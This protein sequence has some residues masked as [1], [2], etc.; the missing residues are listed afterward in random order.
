MLHDISSSTIVVQVII[1]SPYLNIV[2]REVK[3]GEIKSAYFVSVR[4]WDFSNKNK[5]IQVRVLQFVQICLPWDYYEYK[6]YK[7]VYWKNDEAVDIFIYLHE[8]EYTVTLPSQCRG[9]WNGTVRTTVCTKNAHG[10]VITITTFIVFLFCAVILI[11]HH[12]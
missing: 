10:Q 7:F 6:L 2:R 3:K 9:C 5:Y 11:H 1:I 12:F 4:I 8:A